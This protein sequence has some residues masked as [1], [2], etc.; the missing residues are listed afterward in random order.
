MHRW[1]NH[2]RY[3]ARDWTFQDVAPLVEEFVGVGMWL[4]H[5]CEVPPTNAEHSLWIS[6]EP[7]SDRMVN[8]ETTPILPGEG[9]DVD[10]HG[11]RPDARG[12][13]FNSCECGTLGASL[14]GG[15]GRL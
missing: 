7:L 1:V 4:A 2:R 9:R 11:F 8:S 14:V 10:D 13:P 6:P 3:D 12:E 15:D 5:L